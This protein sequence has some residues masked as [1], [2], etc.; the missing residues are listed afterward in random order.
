VLVRALTIRQPWA[1]WIIAGHKDVE[2][3]SWSTSYRGTLAIHSGR[4]VAT[5]CQMALDPAD[6]VL[7]ADV[8]IVTLVDVVGDHPSR[9]ADD[10]CW[11]WLLTRPQRLP[12]PLPMRG[13]LGL[14]TI[15]IPETLL[16][17]Q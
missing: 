11:H 12:E 3:R 10:G 4:S 5:L 13:A 17:G 2:N 6:F 8:G 7:G 15:D 14:F 1:E 9:W 16:P